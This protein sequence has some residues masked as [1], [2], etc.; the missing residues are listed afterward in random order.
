MELGDLRKMTEADMKGIWPNETRDF[1]PWLADNISLLNDVLNIQ[2]EIEELEG[3]VGSFKLDMSGL[4]GVSRRPVVIENQF[5]RSDHDHLGKLL[6]YAADRQAGIM[7]WVA[8]DIQ[9]AHRKAIDWLNRISPPEVSLY[10][11]ELEILTI[12]QSRPAPRFT[13]VAGPPPS[14]RRE[15]TPADQVTSRNRQYQQ[16]FDRLK[17]KVTELQPGFTRARGLPQNWWGL[18]IG[19]TGFSLTAAFTMDA[20]F[21]IEVYIDTGVK[22]DNERALANLDASRHL[23][24]ERIGHQL[25]WDYLPDSR[26]CRVYIMTDGSIDEGGDRLQ[27]L[28]DWGA[29]MM[30]TFREVFG[31]LL[32][33]LDID[34]ET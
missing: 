29:P 13:V 26:G 30:V 4:D 14:K 15:V 5:G 31:P 12:D 33:K 19:R 1:S 16:F 18:G 2:I 32:R 24:E 27:E 9:A 6:T 20:K 23:I 3:P 17:E 11:L 21:R 34:S 7:I 25:Q 22:D 28:I 8:N 10:A